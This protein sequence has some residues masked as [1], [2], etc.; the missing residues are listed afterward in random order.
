M[1]QGFSSCL[2]ISFDREFASV[3]LCTLH[4]SL[5]D[6]RF[7]PFVKAENKHEASFIDNGILVEKK[8]SSVVPPEGED[9]SNKPKKYVRHPR[10][11]AE[12]FFNDEYGLLKIN[13]T[14]ILARYY[15][16]VETLKAAYGSVKMFYSKIANKALNEEDLKKIEFP[17]APK[18]IQVKGID[19]YLKS[20]SL[21]SP[22]PVVKKAMKI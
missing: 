13:E 20:E 12:Y 2:P 17:R 19:H 14:L 9:R 15:E 8:N 6:F 5:I 4:G 18:D 3:V 10:N 16:Y 22:R 1:L 11:V 7:R 21:M